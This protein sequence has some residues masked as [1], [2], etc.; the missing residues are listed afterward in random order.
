MWGILSMSGL[1]I[2][3]SGSQ[4]G[5]PEGVDTAVQTMVNYKPWE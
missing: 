2:N 3:Q 5:F 4:T 1:F